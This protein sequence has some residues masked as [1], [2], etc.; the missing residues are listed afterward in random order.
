MGAFETP[1][2]LTFYHHHNDVLSCIATPLHDDKSM[3]MAL[4]GWPNG[5]LYPYESVIHLKKSDSNFNDAESYLSTSWRSHYD[6]DS[7][8][9]SATASIRRNSTA[10]DSVY[11]KRRDTWSEE[12]NSDK[13]NSIYRF[14]LPRRM[15][16]FV[17]ADGSSTQSGWV[18]VPKHLSINFANLKH[19]FVDVHRSMSYSYEDD[20][21]S[22]FWAPSVDTG[23]GTITEY[24][25]SD[26]EKTKSFITIKNNY[27]CYEN[28]IPCLNDELFLYS[29]QYNPR[30]RPRRCS[31]WIN[32]PYS[33]GSTV[34][35]ITASWR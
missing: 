24:G 2:H 11:S 8:C 1:N 3:M 19:V 25:D 20:R 14:S 6:R 31:I 34:R 23:S 32:T 5:E 12:S 16:S 22:G 28:E 33:G 18:R 9:W 13:R 15:Q 10:N 17:S 27:I 21:T 30:M 4:E 7:M 26:F 29:L 35:H